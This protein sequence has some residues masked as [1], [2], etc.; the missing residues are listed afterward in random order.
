MQKVPGLPSPLSQPQF[1]QRGRMEMWR[2]LLGPLSQTGNRHS[3]RKHFHLKW[4]EPI[5]F[6]GKRQCV[7]FQLTF[8]PTKRT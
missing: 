3:L 2:S 1:P 5:D 6:L 8:P 7:Y 4:F